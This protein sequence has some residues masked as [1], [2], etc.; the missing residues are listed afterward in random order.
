MPKKIFLYLSLLFC[1]LLLFLVLSQNER[2][3]KDFKLIVKRKEINANEK[4]S[5]TIIHTFV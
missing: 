4:T 2:K 5:K 1:T 3:P